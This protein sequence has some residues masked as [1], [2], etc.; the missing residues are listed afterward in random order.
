MA[1]AKSQEDTLP[2]LG[3]VNEVCK[4]WTV[5]EDGAL[6]YRLQNE[7]ISDH[8]QGNKYRNAVVREDFPRAL[9]EQI[10]EQQLAEQAAAVYHQMLAEQEEIDNLY[11]QQLADKLE[12]EEKAKRRALEAHDERIA[13]LLD[14]EYGIPNYP[15]H[16]SPQRLTSASAHSLDG[17]PPS[18]YRPDKRNYNASSPRRQAMLMPLPC[19]SNNTANSNVNINHVN[20][21]QDHYLYT[22]PYKESESI[23]DRFDQINI[24][25]V[26]LPLD[27][28][29]ERE[30]QEQKDALLARQLQL[31]EDANGQSQVDRDRLLAIEAQDKELAKLLQ[32]RERQKVK[33]A[34][35]RAKQKALAKKQQQQQI[36]EQDI[37]QIMPDDSYSN[38]ADLLPS[39]QNI[40]K[41]FSLQSNTSQKYFHNQN[42]LVGNDDVNYSFP[43]DVIP[44]KSYD[45]SMKQNYS[46]KKQYDAQPDVQENSKT[47]NGINVYT[48]YSP[49]KINNSDL[50]Q[51]VRPTQL[52][53]KTPLNYSSKPR[54]PDPEFFE[55]QLSSPSQHMNIAMAIDPTYNRRSQHSVPYCDT[56]SSTVTTSTSSSSPGIVLP[57]PDISEHEE[58]SSP[59]PPYMPIQG[60]RRTASLE[61]KSK[62]KSKDGCKQ[63]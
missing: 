53:L 57:P 47:I 36:Q 51:P 42:Q 54:Y 6:A 10:R 45:H 21:P 20:I 19:D 24:A 3:R 32:E 16:K 63:Q 48:N 61:K 49:E 56:S 43:V 2:K 40:D 44:S 8:Y 41:G 39:P 37:H 7:E 22:E 11:A 25:E 17:Y 13:H 55:G 26:G 23:A 59:V 12:R 29:T 33:R 52:D 30:I 38:P 9:D 1:N 28:V 27:E 5:R 15:P 18:P 46:P 50:Q 4:E 34:K 62:K 60:Q 14:S 58:D 31:Q 35:E